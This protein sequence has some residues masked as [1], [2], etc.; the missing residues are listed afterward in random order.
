MRRKP[1]KPERGCRWTDLVE[2]ARYFKRA[3]GHADSRGDEQP[4]PDREDA[5]P[6]ADSAVLKRPGAGK[7]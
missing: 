3:Q 6:G 5:T 2:F 4:V 1:P 7:R